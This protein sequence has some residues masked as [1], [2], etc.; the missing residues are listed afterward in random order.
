MNRPILISALLASLLA[1]S[2]ATHLAA[3]T[4]PAFELPDGWTWIPATDSEQV[5]TA[6][7]WRQDRFRYAAA[8]HLYTTDPSARLTISF[9]GTA[10]GIRLGGHNTPPYGGQGGAN[11]GLL[12]CNIDGKR[13]AVFRPQLEG[14]E[15]LLADG[16]P[17]GE[18]RLTL[19]H[20]AD[21]GQTGCRVEGFFACQQAPGRLSFSLQGEQQAF[22]VDARATIKRGNET[23]RSEIVRNWLNGECSLLVPA[24]NN[25]SLQLDTLGWL[26][27]EVNPLSVTNGATTRVDPLFAKRDAA[28]VAYRFRFPALNRQAIRMPGESF[29]ARFLGFDTTIKQVRIVRRNGPATF[30]RLLDFVEDKQAAYYYDREVTAQLPEDTPTGVYDLE[31]TIEGGRRTGI[32]RSAGSVVVVAEYPTRPLLLSFGHLDTNGQYQ[33]EY[34][35]RIAAIANLSGAD[36]V[37]NSNAVNPAYIS[38]AL[39]G[40]QIPYVV[41]FGNHQVRG[42]EQWYGDPVG[43]VRFGPGLAILNFGHPWHTET[44]AAEKLLARHVDTTIKVIN[45]FEANAPLELLD[46]HSIQLIHDA[47]GIG[48]KVKELGMTPTLRVGKVS[49]TSFRMIQFD[50]QKVVSATYQDHPTAPFPLA[51]DEIPP[52][53]IRY[54]PANDGSSRELA[55]HISNEYKQAFPQARATVLLP[56]GPN[57]VIKIAGPQFRI[58]ATNISDDGK[59]TEFILRLN[60]DAESEVTLA[61]TSPLPE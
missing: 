22:L 3:E 53:R 18:H 1:L 54:L 9:S 13:I 36:M 28:T 32:C 8:A 4:I 5:E 34:L 49:S 38:G 44:A 27:I 51:R 50:Q 42:H 39:S 60:L 37:L 35:S 6:G 7:Q 29:R 20:Q 24:G 19:Y 41:N 46:K 23:I 58:E 57:P 14:R 59:Y 40:L 26:P 11:L 12:L 55:V 2:A 30:S 31:V 47:H 52:L 15:I 33:A 21:R 25:Y 43:L 48:D 45:A 61:I 10:I 17:A 56:F 16:L